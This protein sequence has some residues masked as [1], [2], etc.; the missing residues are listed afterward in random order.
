MNRWALV[1]TLTSSSLCKSNVRR[2]QSDMTELYSRTWARLDLSAAVLSLS[3][4]W[5]SQHGCWSRQLLEAPSLRSPPSFNLTAETEANQPQKH[6]QMPRFIKYREVLYRH[7]S[8]ELDIL[9]SHMLLVYFLCWSTQILTEF[10][11]TAMFSS[12]KRLM[13]MKVWSFNWLF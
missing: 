5:D 7:R 3:L 2:W 8:S 11:Q 10:R 12:P 1:S 13:E 4:R 6:K 9:V